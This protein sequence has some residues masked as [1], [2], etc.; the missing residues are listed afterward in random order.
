MHLSTNIFVPHTGKVMVVCKQAHQFW[1]PVNS[2]N[3]QEALS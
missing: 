3:F 2:Q 1:L